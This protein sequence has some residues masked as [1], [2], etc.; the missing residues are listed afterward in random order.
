MALIGIV[1][2]AG[3]LLNQSQGSDQ[4]Q[5]T[6]GKQ[7]AFRAGTTNSPDGGDQYTPSAQNAAQEAGLFQ[8]SNFSVFTA[9]ADNF[10][11]Q[12]GAAKADA[13][14]NAGNATVTAG[15]H[16]TGASV[17]VAAQGAAGNGGAAG[18]TA[19][20]AAA[21]AT[22]NTTVAAAGGSTSGT[23]AATSTQTQVQDFN[24]SL[25]AL[26]LSQAEIAVIDRVAQLIKD[27]NPLAYSDL[28]S[29]L[30]SL[31]ESAA[32]QSAVHN[33]AQD[34][35]ATTATGAAQT[36]KANAAQG[37]GQTATQSAASTAN[38]AAAANAG[39][40]IQELSIRFSGAEGN[41]PQ[42][43]GNGQISAAAQ[44][45]AYNLQIEEVQIT[46]G[47]AAGQTAQVQAPL[48]KNTAA[49]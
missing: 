16:A 12:A 23:T 8:V 2:S 32:P 14:S 9:A 20:N 49:G 1:Q 42:Q 15:G 38:T 45:S 13:G 41:V 24:A 27:F 6:N 34:A 3:R 22:A 44:F 10:I 39:F 25:A 29:Q 46:L 21:N 40:A 4:F 31:A 47:N 37:A 33:A 7:A 30:E 18:T 17:A 48:L 26:G 36:A 5:P 11:A 35:A 19:Q 43:S 28:I